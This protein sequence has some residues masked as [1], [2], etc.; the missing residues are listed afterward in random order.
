[1]WLLYHTSLNS[2]STLGS[3]LGVR[4]NILVILL[5]SE[6]TKPCESR[7]PSQHHTHLHIASLVSMKYFDFVFGQVQEMEYVCSLYA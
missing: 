3:K 2:E 4:R 5:C 7:P 1:M 6:W